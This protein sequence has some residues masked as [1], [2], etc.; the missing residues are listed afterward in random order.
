M[1]R[2][3]RKLQSWQGVRFVLVGL[4]QLALDT[5]LFV[6]MTAAGLP[7]AIANPISRGLVV[8]AGFW[9]HGSYTF[10]EAGVPKTRWPYL[11]R[12]LPAWVVLTTIGTVALAVIKSND[13]L[14]ATWIAKPLV[15]G[16]LAVM[17]YFTLRRWVFRRSV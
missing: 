17:S 11:A 3:A 8:V 5:G 4:A 9:M 12:F 10:A 2:H 16:L 13:G 7:P 1:W 15:D 14:H 6:L